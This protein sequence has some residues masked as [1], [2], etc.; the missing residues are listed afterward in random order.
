M[1]T[2]VFYPSR[3]HASKKTTKRFKKDIQLLVERLDSHEDT[4]RSMP[5]DANDIIPRQR[6]MMRPLGLA[7]QADRQNAT[8]PKKQ[9]TKRK[10]KADRVCS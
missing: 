1:I 10:N 8:G 9:A 2:N 7:K 6:P 5:V 4:F 3:I